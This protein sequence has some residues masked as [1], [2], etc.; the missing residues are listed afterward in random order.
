VGTVSLVL[1]IDMDSF[2]ASCEELRHPE[3]KGKAFVVGT[4]DEENKLKGVVET[5]NYLAK[6]AGIKS[7]MP[8]SMA[9]KIKKDIIYVPSDHGYYDKVSADIMQKLRSYNFRTE[10]V[11]I[12]EAAL[13]LGEMSYEDAEK[14][15]LKIKDE[16]NSNMGLPCTVGI[17]EGKIFAKMVCDDAK[18]DGLKVIKKKDMKEFLNDKNVEKILGVGKKTA[19]RLNAIGIKTIGDLAKVDQ[20]KLANVVG[21]FGGELHRLANGEDDSKVTE[22]Y[23]VLSIGRERTLDKKTID[24]TEINKMLDSLADEVMGEVEKQGFSFKT[25]TVKARYTDFTEKIKGKSLANYSNSTDLLKKMSHDLI[26]ELINLKLVRKVGVKVSA[27]TS[28]KGQHKLF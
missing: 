25:I 7:A 24:L 13:D 16:I 21:S 20:A 11:S 27:F 12:D 5:A 19:E 2:Y 14:L 26:K 28:G 15:G 4:G 10:P 6:R 1:F 9:Y 3:L 8:T 17:S 18:P 22:H 23:D